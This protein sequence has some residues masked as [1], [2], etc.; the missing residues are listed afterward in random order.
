M[1]SMWGQIIVIVAVLLGYQHFS[2]HIMICSKGISRQSVSRKA[3]S[4]LQN[5]ILYLVSVKIPEATTQGFA[6]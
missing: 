4:R 1:V 3:R 5:D 2:I 6:V